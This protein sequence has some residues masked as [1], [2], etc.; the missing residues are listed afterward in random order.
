MYLFVFVLGVGCCY[1]YLVFPCCFIGIRFAPLRHTWCMRF[2]SKNK[3]IKEFTSGCFKNVPYSI[4]QRHQQMMVY[5]LAVKPE[6]QTSTFIY[7]GVEVLSGIMKSMHN[8]IFIISI[9]NHFLPGSTEVVGVD[10]ADD[11]ARVC[12]LNEPCDPFTALRYTSISC[13]CS[14][15]RSI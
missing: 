9:H 14:H 11:F 10:I 5:L 7:R 2:E 13:M 6:Q 15:Y 3:Q 12:G 8:N 4:A 1:M